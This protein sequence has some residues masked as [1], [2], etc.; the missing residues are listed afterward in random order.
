M[1]QLLI[2]LV[3]ASLTFACRKVQNEDPTIFE[4]KVVYE[5]DGSP[6][7]GAVL[8]IVAELKSPFLTGGNSGEHKEALIGENG[9]FKLNFSYN[10]QI[11]Y[12]ISTLYFKD[13]NGLA[14]KSFNIGNGMDCSPHNCSDFKASK[15]YNNL[16]IK[17]PRP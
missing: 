9:T 4:G 1:K 5:D 2:L 7:T 13:S 14:T 11:S 3:L 16:V 15:T 10:D 8:L 6:A 12:F 17:I